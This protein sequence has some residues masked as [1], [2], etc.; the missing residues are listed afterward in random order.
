MVQ[1][2][3]AQAEASTHMQILCFDLEGEDIKGTTQIERT[4]SSSKV[5]IEPGDECLFFVAGA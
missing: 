4:S 1:G 2:Q 3:V 5:I